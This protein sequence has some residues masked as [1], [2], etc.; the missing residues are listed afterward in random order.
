MGRSIGE[1]ESR[2]APRLRVRIPPLRLL[3]LALLV[4]GCSGELLSTPNPDDGWHCFDF[5]GDFGCVC[6]VGEPLIEPTGDT[7]GAAGCCFSFMVFDDLGEPTP[8]C[9]CVD[10][11][12]G[13]CDAVVTP[14]R[15]HHDAKVQRSCP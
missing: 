8:T 1:S 6:E 11:E 15:A 2:D 5:A 4:V 3:M 10:A 12:A 9:R 14:Y 13:E 7:C